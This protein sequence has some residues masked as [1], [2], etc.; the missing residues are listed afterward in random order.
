MKPLTYLFDNASNKNEL[1]LD[2][3]IDAGMSNIAQLTYVNSLSGGSS[4][5][6]ADEKPYVADIP[7]KFG[8][9]DTNTSRW[10]AVLNK[11]DNFCK[12]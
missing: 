11:Y 3:V 5:I 10:V 8:T 4:C 7:W 12:N 2:I 1:P 6:N 9:Q